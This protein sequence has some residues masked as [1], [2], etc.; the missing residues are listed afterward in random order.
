MKSIETE[1][2]YQAFILERLTQD[3]GYVLRTNQN[4]DRYY[5]L[6]RE[7]LLQFL[8]ATQPEAME[9]LRKIFKDKTEDTITGAISAAETQKGGSRLEVL[10]HGLEINRIHL[11]LLYG[12]PATTY[13]KE[14]NKLYQ[15][16][17]FS[18]AEEIWASDQERI[19]VVIFINGL[20]VI[21]ME[22]KANTQ[23]Q[24]Y[25]D[26]IW[27]YRNDRD[28]KS[29]LLRFKA[30]ALV[31][32][33]M[34]LEQCYMTT[35]L[36]KKSTF[37]LPFN[38]G[39]GTGIDSG[40][41]NP[42][43]EDKYSVYYMWEKIFQKDSL[44]EIITRFM[45][46][47]KQEKK[48]NLTGK[49]KKSERVI[50][51][52][53]HQLDVI[54]KVL[55]DVYENKSEQN[56]LLQ[57]S[58]GSGKTNEI[59]WLA[60]RLATIHDSENQVIFNNVIICTD[61]VVVDRQLQHAVTSLEHKSGF[62]KP[63]D[64]N[65]TS[66]DLAA[67]IMGN[68]KIVITTI[69]KFPYILDSVGKVKD[70]RFAVL[71]DEAHSSTAGKNMN[72]LTKVL[73]TE[74][75]YQD[76]DMDMDEMIADEYKRTGKQP[77]VAMFAFTATPKATTL[78]Q[79]GSLNVNGQKEAF[80][81]YSMKQAIEEKFILDVLQNYITYDTYYKLNKSI[82]DDPELKTSDAKRQIAR[83]VSLHDENVKQRIE[84]IVEHFR[85]TVMQE[86]G[87][88]A[89]AMVV[90]S[91][92]PEAVKYKLEMDKYI[93]QQ[94]YRDMRTLVAF[95][96]K[97]KLEGHAQEFTEPGLNGFSEKMLPSE[98]ARDDYQLLLVADKYQTGFDQP[99]LCAMYILKKLSG[100]STIQTLSR[101]N[102]ICPPFEKHTFILDFKN[103]YEDVVKDFSVYYTTTLLSNTVTPRAIYDLEVKLDGW[104]IA[105]PEGIEKFN[106]LLYKGK[107]EKL[108]AADQKSMIYHLQKS[109]KQIE[110]YEEE[111]RRQIVSSIRK[112]VRF[113][114]FLIQVTCFE[115]KELHE[116]TNK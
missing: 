43:F 97:V 21:T 78:E 56:Y 69:Q 23:G 68:T 33:A 12:K 49:I 80:H 2:E 22:L 30:G 62:V 116:T 98:F 104:Y 35:E 14:L 44:L 31:H 106:Q 83:Y 32:F 61:R 86:L 65:C 77:N 3:N 47:E 113:Y 67:A 36:K 60:Y 45:F 25:K 39:S 115:D 82:Q 41:G 89:K 92:R 19:D 51:P 107:K 91:S 103:K 28:P 96:G 111:E 54:R 75:S 7:M 93:E 10:K 15:E 63:L 73:S 84:V 112:F 20:A 94:G 17:I 16:N 66:A 34:D 27:Q 81:I 105:E 13:N 8:E 101:L 100:I 108:T 48:D 46:I 11:N 52:R 40:A 109:K 37:F 53:F 102:R 1:K 90:T 9:K 55:A 57:H 76:A 58:A 99:K 71:I 74:Q 79:F 64:D 50:F 114:E 85:A 110:G 4:F 95:S 18:V 42:I 88:Q 72:A 38:M 87:G 5:A 26:A 29:R 24:S 70:K 59:A 6:D